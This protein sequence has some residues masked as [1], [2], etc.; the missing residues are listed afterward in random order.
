MSTAELDLEIPESPV[1]APRCTERVLLDALHRRYGAAPMGA[2]RYVVAEHVP[3]RPVFAPRVADFV[4]MDVWESSGLEIHG[5]EVKVSRSDWLREM[6]EPEKAAEF[7]P[8]VHRW[9]LVVPDESIVR[10][11]ELPE[12]WG[13][14][15]LRGS[16]LRAARRAPRTDAL[17]L[18]PVR[19]AA[20]VRAVQKTAATR[21]TTP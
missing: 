11:G 3:S 9:W 14:M 10:P 5:H 13:L 8:Y 21:G 18:T 4:A 19:L 1:P 20:F 16:Q 2:R 12:T 17:P 7:T 15:T 6:K